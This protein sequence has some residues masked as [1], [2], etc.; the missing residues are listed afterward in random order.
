MSKYRIKPLCKVYEDCGGCTLQHIEYKYQ[1]ILKKNNLIE[2]FKRLGGFD[3]TKI[4]RDIS[5]TNCF[6]YRNKTV[7]PMKK[8]NNNNLAIGYYKKFT[9]DIIDIVECP[10]L[11]ENINP[12]IS[13]T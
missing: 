1:L 12:I 8:D 4:M 13:L 11:L 7:L 3:I 5:I 9:H 6:N 2:Q 10:I